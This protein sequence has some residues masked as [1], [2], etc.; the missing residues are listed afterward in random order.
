LKPVKIGICGLGTVGSGTVNV[1]TRNSRVINARAGCD[2]TIAQVA[3][4]RMDVNCP[5]D[6]LNV[7]DDIFAVAD[8]PEVDILVEL[9]GGIDTARELILRAIAN[10]KH[11]VTANKALIAEHGNELF[12]AANKQGVTVAFEAAVAGG[13]P[14]IK[15]IREGLSSNNIEWLAG[16]INGTGNF[17]LTEMRDKGRGFSEVLEEAQELG[18][19]EADPTFDIEG[20]DAAHK[21]VILASIAF[22]IPLQF[23][24]VFTEGISRISPQD[25]IYAQEL[26]YAIKHLGI[27]RRSPDG[28]E[29]R[30]HPTLIPKSRLLANVD[31]VM[32]AILVKGD[33]VGPT[34][35][36]GAGAGAEPTASAVIAD[37]VD[38]AR[39]LTASPEHRVPFLGFQQENLRD[40]TILPIEEV[41][42][43]YYLRMS[44][45][46][47][48]GVL[49][50]VA[51]ILSESGISIEALIQKEAKDEQEIV[52]LILLT[53]RAVEKQLVE[54][55]IKIEALSSI[56]GPITR[57]RVEPLK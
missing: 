1:L 34:L 37:I 18:Y 47:K 9:I 43:A 25:V 26:G 11:V 29:L 39:T 5:L 32:N 50:Q 16:I 35:Y 17:I 27:A 23:D 3:T 38:A 13:I 57:I 40:K 53:N 56:T 2:L 52:P 46:D 36:Y 6:D 41:E 51:Q 12:A 8:N 44:A 14:I 4:R 19:A 10:G 30:V 22:G 15:A 42:T 33:A 24:K 28:I 20:I 21:L 49:S 45:L 7:T 31:G 55:I 48:P 54:A